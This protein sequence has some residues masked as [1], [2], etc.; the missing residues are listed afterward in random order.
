MKHEIGVVL[1][2]LWRDS[3]PS[4]LVQNFWES[5]ALLNRSFCVLEKTPFLLGNSSIL[6]KP[7]SDSSIP[8][9]DM[10]TSTLWSCLQILSPFGRVLIAK[11]SRFP[12]NAGWKNVSGLEQSFSQHRLNRRF[13]NTHI[14][15]TG[16]WICHLLGFLGF[17][18]VAPVCSLSGASVQPV[19]SF[20]CLVVCCFEC[21]TGI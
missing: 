14:G 1:W 10:F 12:K 17:S 20:H 9:V 21:C 5:R 18:L 4:C 16:E 2:A 15:S 7:W 13:E 11:S 19:I 6:S 3:N 8:S